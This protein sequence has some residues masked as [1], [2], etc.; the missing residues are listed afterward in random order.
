MKKARGGPSNQA[1]KQ[2]ALKADLCVFTEIVAELLLIRDISFSVHA[3]IADKIEVCYFI[4]PLPS[5]GF[6]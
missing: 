4:G 6:V 3:E 5:T 1:N 2:P